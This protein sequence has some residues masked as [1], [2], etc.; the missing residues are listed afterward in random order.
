MNKI[1][2]WVIAVAIAIVFNL[3]VNYG[4]STFYSGPEYTD[5]CDEPRPRLV[6]EQLD[7]D[8]VEV[9]EELRNSCTERKAYIGYTYDSN[10]CPTEAYCETCGTEYG[11]VRKGYDG[12]VFVVL[13]IVAVIALSLGVKLK[14]EAVSSGFL[15]A[16]VIGL[17][18][19]STRYWSHLQDIYRFVL[20]GAV[21]AVLIWLGYKKIK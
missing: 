21:L 16:G 20:L 6:R 17:L 14:V 10:G 1:K 2:L 5:F 12:N 11:D 19:A 15:L 13:L 9:S 3:F 18:I 7:C 4:I 8:I